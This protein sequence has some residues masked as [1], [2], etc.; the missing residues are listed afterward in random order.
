MTPGTAAAAA[1]CIAVLL[2]ACSEGGH[3]VPCGGEADTSAVVLGPS[4]VEVFFDIG[5]GWRVSG[6]DSFTGWPPEAAALPRVG[7]YLDASYEAIAALGPT[8]VH[9]V[10]YSPDIEH[11]AAELGIPYY[12]YS[13]DTLDDVFDSVTRLESLYGVEGDR[14]RSG[15]LSELDSLRESLG[16]ASR[17]VL[18]VIYHQ[19]GSGTMTLA[20][21]GTFLEDLVEAMGCSLAAPDQGTYPSVSVEGVLDLSPDR[22]VCLFPGAPD[23]EASERLEREFWSGFGY[24]SGMVSVLAEDY[25]L[26]PGPRMALTA[27][28][29]SECLR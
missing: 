9:S 7:G 14:F 17:S 2:S 27:A 28:R 22:I 11:M 26:V 13:F 23:R 1:A 16:G 25:L 15:L 6:V 21:R 10:G 24:D 29:I 3:P 20:G 5:I 12:G 19:A 8:S 4:L 18:L